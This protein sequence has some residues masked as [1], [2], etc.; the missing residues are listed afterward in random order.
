MDAD[1]GGLSW[2]DGKLTV[3]SLHLGVGSRVNFWGNRWCGDSTLRISFPT[4]INHKTERRT[5]HRF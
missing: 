3:A 5:C 4:Y 2:K 1:Y